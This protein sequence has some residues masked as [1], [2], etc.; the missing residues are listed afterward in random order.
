VKKNILTPD[1][2]EPCNRRHPEEDTWMLHCII[3]IKQI[4]GKHK[5]T[6][7]P[8]MTKII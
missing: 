1:L 4:A 2:L 5:N 3:N 7:Y 8:I 6:Y